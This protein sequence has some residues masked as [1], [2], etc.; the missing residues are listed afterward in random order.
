MP[1]NTGKLPE[2]R[3]RQGRIS[4]HV[5]SGA[6]PCQHLDISLL[7][8]RLR[9]STFLFFKPQFVVPC[10]GS[11][12]TPTQGAVISWNSVSTARGRGDEGRWQPALSGV[13][14]QDW[15]LRGE[16]PPFFLAAPTRSSTPRVESL[17]PGAGVGVGAHCG[18]NA[19]D[20]LFWLRFSRFS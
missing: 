14:R 20:S 19:M 16:G 11:P 15:E 9:D 4:R 10:W 2:A 17:S 18:S 8:S 1:E 7:G 6:R 13:K 5:P 3:K 12:G